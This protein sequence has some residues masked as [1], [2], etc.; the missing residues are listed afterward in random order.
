MPAEVPGD[1][2]D[3]IFQSIIKSI[4][5]SIRGDDATVDLEVHFTS[6]QIDS[7]GIPLIS[8]KQTESVLEIRL[9]TRIRKPDV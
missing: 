4:G 9:A 6:I 5:S 3:A 8:R 1:R 2:I 7:K